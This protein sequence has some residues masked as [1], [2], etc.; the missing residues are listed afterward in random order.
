MTSTIDLLRTIWTK[1]I[2]AEYLQGLLPYEGTLQAAIFS[3]IRANP[4][5]YKVFAEVPRFLGRGNPDLVITKGDHVEA[6]IELKFVN[7]AIVYE[8]DIDKLVWWARK[9]SKGSQKAD[10]KLDPRTIQLSET[11]AFRVTDKTQWI[12]AAI[13]PEGYDALCPE[14]VRGYLHKKCRTKFE[15]FWLFT[16]I[17]GGGSLKAK[18]ACIRL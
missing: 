2:G 10:L 9:A 16:G 14:T 17:V 8:H 15:N 11:D 13:G 18:F 6:V 3:H 4:A 1:Q 7:G 12:F 5:G